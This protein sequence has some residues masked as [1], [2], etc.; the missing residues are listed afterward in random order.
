MV[1]A[2]ELLDL[3]AQGAAH[4][5]PHDQLDALGARLAQVL[6]VR[7]L[8][9]RVRVVDQLVEERVVELGVDEPGAR[10]LQLV[11]HAAGAPD[12]DV[13]VLV[14]ALHR[15]AH[16]LAELEAAIAGRRRVL[17]DVD[18]ERD[19]LHRPRLGLA[20]HQGQRHGEAVVDVIL[21]MMVMS[22]SSR[23]SDCGDVRGQVG[24]AV[25]RPAPGGAPKP[26]S[27]GGNARR[28]RSRTSG[29]SPART[30]RRGRCRPGPRR[31]GFPGGPGLGPLVAGEQRLPVGLARSCRGRSPRRWP[32]RGWWPPRR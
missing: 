15:P 10:A 23:I 17:H 28:S 6:D 30:P 31:P 1:E 14:V 32:A 21:L 20:E 16:G 4:D 26:S 8:R 7:H 2:V 29:R 13:E 5:Q 18:R 12:L 27:A 19:D 24:V 22:N 9:Q 25:G 11:A 3:L